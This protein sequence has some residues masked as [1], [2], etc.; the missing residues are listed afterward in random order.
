MNALLEHLPLW[1]ACGQQSEPHR[2]PSPVG[3]VAGVVHGGYKEVEVAGGVALLE[4]D[5][6]WINRAHPSLLYI[7]CCCFARGRIC[8]WDT[9][10]GLGGSVHNLW[11]ELLSSLL[12]AHAAVRYYLVA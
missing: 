3:L 11:A 9:W 1:Q 8:A 10:G 2:R 12:M 7:S 4:T 5:A 6:P